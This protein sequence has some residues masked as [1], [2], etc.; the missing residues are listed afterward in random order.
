MQKSAVIQAVD[1]PDYS[2]G[3]YWREGENEL[4]NASSLFI[5]QFM[6]H[7]KSLLTILR[8]CSQYT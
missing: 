1:Q 5:H 2:L 8:H 4:G 7:F 3:I 6:I